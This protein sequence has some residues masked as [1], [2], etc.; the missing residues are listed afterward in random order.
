[1]LT[2]PFPETQA[3]VSELKGNG[4]W[5]GSS[6]YRLIATFLDRIQQLAPSGVPFWGQMA[7]NC[8]ELGILM[9]AT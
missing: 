3:R 7:G 4:G 2:F 5:L 1:M 9:T 8:L 6:C